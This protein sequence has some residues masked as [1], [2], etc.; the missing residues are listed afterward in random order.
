[1]GKYSTFA[2]LLKDQATHSSLPQVLFTE[3]ADLRA[4]TSRLAISSESPAE[5]SV[6]SIS[7]VV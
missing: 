4:S 2:N 3:N 7:D 5:V 6:E 1:M